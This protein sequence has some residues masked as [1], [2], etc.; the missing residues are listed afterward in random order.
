MKQTNYY[1]YDFMDFA[2]DFAQQRDGVAHSDQQ[3]GEALWKAHAPSGV[4]ERDGDVV[5][6]IPYQRQLRQEDMA[7]DETV[8][9]RCYDLTIRAYA[10]NMVRIFTSMCGDGMTE[11]DGMLQMSPEVRRMPLRYAGGDIVLGAAT[12]ILA[13][14]EGRRAAASINADLRG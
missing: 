5:V 9:Q 3:V 7:P 11:G 4:R 10:P 6:S 1:L 2:N 14:G 12:V 13:M 8:A